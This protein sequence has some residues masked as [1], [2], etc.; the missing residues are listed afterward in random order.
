MNKNNIIAA[1][2]FENASAMLDRWRQTHVGNMAEFYEF[3][4]T[5]GVDRDKFEDSV[6]TGYSIS[7]G[8]IIQNL[9]ANNG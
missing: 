4:T 8:I 1:P 3:M 7:S 5:P 6:N 2:S 9:T